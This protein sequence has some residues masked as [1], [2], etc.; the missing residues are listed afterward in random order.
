MTFSWVFLYT[1]NY[2]ARST[3]HQMTKQ[4][5][6]KRLY[7]NKVRGTAGQ[8]TVILRM[9]GMTEGKLYINIMNAAC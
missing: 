9:S 6:P 2:D 8:D 1:L 3:T 4:I 7:S 5:P